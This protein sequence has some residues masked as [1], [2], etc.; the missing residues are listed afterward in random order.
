MS[1]FT[2]AQVREILDQCPDDGILEVEGMVINP[3]SF[4]MEM[5]VKIPY[6]VIKEEE[7]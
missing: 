1:N 2:V 4:Q 7:E 5:I 3:K 6:Q